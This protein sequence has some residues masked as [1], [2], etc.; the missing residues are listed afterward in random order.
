MPTGVYIKSEEHKKKIGQRMLGNK[1]WL[2]KKHSE[3]TKKKISE[4][5]KDRKHSKK[6]KKK[7]SE[8][9]MGKKYH[10]GFKH[11]E[12]TKQKI[13][14][15]H[16][17]KKLSKEIKRK[18]SLAHMGKQSGM[19]GKKLSKETKRKIS[20]ALG[21]TGIPQTTKRY[22]RLRDRKYM[23]WRSKVFERD[24]WTCQTCGKRSQSGEQVYL[25]SHHIKSWAKYPKSRYD[26]E[27]G[28]CL[29]VE[30]HRLTRKKYEGHKRNS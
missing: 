30:C 14:E 20:L 23:E 4:T 7:M 27:N 19:L 16:K 6:S 25:E 28:V 9:K 12:K 22:Y 8:A 24:N 15:V 17:G 5:L 10:L 21:G 11:T 1:Y 18:M 29:C 3:E 13:S 26:V 2:G